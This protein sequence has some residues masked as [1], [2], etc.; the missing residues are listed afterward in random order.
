M[1]SSDFCRP[2]AWLLPLVILLFAGCQP[3]PKETP[4]TFTPS[5][6]VA[7]PTVAPTAT[8]TDLPE[9]ITL[10]LWTVAQ[11]SPEAEGQPG[12]FMQE[13]LRA[14]RQANPN[15]ELNI[16]LKKPSGKGGLLDFLR[17]TKQ[18][19]PSI[20][21]DVVI[22]DATDLNQ[23]YLDGL[24]QPLDDRLN[25]L[26][27]QDLLPAA[28]LMGTVDGKLAGAPISIEMEHMVYNTRVFTAP[29]LLWTDVLSSQARYLFP[30]KGDN[31]LVNDATLAQYFSAGG[32]LRNDQGKPTI[33]E[34]ALHSLLDFYHQALAQ[35]VI[36]PLILEVA[37][38][39]EIWSAYR[40]GQ[41]D[42]A[43]V[44]VRQYLTD[45]ASL[46]QTMFAPIPVQD[47]ADTPTAMT[48]GWVVVLITDDFY[49]QRAALSLMEWFLSTGR[50][51]AWNALNHSIPT[52]DSAYRQVAGSD[53][54][55]EF[56]T[57]QLNTA[58][59]YPRFS[60]YSQVGRIIQQAVQQVIGGE[61][62]P[63]EATTAA[64][65]ALAQ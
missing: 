57:Q 24:V 31:G 34:Q 50:N 52:T 38:T 41:A 61:A 40:Q 14:F 43:H 1:A 37:T 10:T 47:A 51:A 59:P 33:D 53:P 6:I 55:W 16:I 23:A 44:T 13:T 21:P 26:L 42:I 17:T 39:E 5:P 62:T 3:P 18:A 8:P 63:Q 45:R 30:A 54:Y 49:R 19:A 15:I 22:M 25:R 65:D 36:T 20:L 7:V 64:I 27:V 4:S 29:P 35:R 56:L 60:G 2:L 46:E 12:I 32:R 48:H 11:I 58:R 28:R 9:T